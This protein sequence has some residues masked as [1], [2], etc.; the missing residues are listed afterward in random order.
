[1]KRRHSHRSGD[2]SVARSARSTTAAT[3]SAAGARGSN[4]ALGVDAAPSRVS[5]TRI[6]PG[7]SG[8]RSPTNASN[9]STF[10]E[11]YASATFAARLSAA[12]DCTAGSMAS[13]CETAL[14]LCAVPTAAQAPGARRNVS[15][16]THRRTSSSTSPIRPSAVASAGPMRRRLLSRGRSPSARSDAPSAAA[17]AAHRCNCRSSAAGRRRITPATAA[18]HVTR[19]WVAVLARGDTA[20]AMACTT[21]VT[22]G[23]AVGTQS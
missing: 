3:A 15:F 18:A 21:A 19:P 11:P 16:A 13:E 22:I 8:G 9:D 2:S 4:A 20:A 14:S 17:I 12:E 7:A 6:R 5:S 10:P 23:C 1:M